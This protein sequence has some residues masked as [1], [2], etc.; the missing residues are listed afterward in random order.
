MRA[1]TD[2]NHAVDRIVTDHRRLTGWALFV[3]VVILSAIAFWG[4]PVEAVFSRFPL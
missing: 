1:V 4:V 2:L 3:V